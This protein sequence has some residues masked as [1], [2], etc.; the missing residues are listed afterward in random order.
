MSRLRK[1]NY[2][3]ETRRFKINDEYVEISFD[4]YCD[5][6]IPENEPATDITVT[7]CPQEILDCFGER[8]IET[9]IRE[10]LKNEN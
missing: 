8:E 6:K 1:K 5:V 10:E 7:D 9:M 2:G 4:W 3:S